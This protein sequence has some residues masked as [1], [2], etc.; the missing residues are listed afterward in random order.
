MRII[1]QLFLLL[2]FVPLA[3]AIQVNIPIEEPSIIEGANYSINVNYSENSHLFDGYST[4]GYKSWLESYFYSIANPLGY[5]NSTTLPAQT[6]YN[7]T[8]L[9]L[10]WSDLNN[11]YNYNTS[12][13]TSTTDYGYYL[14]FS[15]GTN[16]INVGSSSTLNPSAIA[17]SAWVKSYN[18]WVIGRDKS[19]GRSYAFGVDSA[20]RAFMQINGA[21][22]LTVNSA[23]VYDGNWHHVVWQGNSSIGYQIYVDGVNVGNA[24][25]VAMASTP[26]TV[27]YIGRREYSGSEGYATGNL[28]QVL[29]FNR[30]LTQTEIN[31]LYNSGSGLYTNISASPF[32]SGLVSAW[33]FDK[34]SGTSA[35][36]VKGLNNGTISGASWVEPGKILVGETTGWS[37]PTWNFSDTV[38]IAKG[39]ETATPKDL[40]SAQGKSN[41]LN[42][43]LGKYEKNLILTKEGVLKEVP[44]IAKA[45]RG[46]SWSVDG[47]VHWLYQE[48]LNIIL[49]NRK[50]DALILQLQNNITSLSNR[51][52]K[53][54]NVKL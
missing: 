19:G 33:E 53:L 41:E 13:E 5:Y 44:Q 29:F 27:T 46:G 42:Y 54:E 17:V 32:N 3:L 34:G 16:G 37:N 25:W 26:S 10:N 22:T 7:S 23:G 9:I 24:S 15:G 14:N 11:W 52:A 48:V 39:Y 12:Y 1:K 35:T 38:F 51:I 36:D 47:M 2:V 18:S 43:L 28:D 50:Q 30:S 21:G 31:Q 20:N 4:T 40:L 45:T 49:E 6:N 8:G